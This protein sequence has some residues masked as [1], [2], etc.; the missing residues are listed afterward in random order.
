MMDSRAKNTLIG[1]SLLFG[2]ILFFFGG[3]EAILRLTGV[4]TVKPNPPRI[5]QRSAI[6]IISYELKP[7]I[8]LPAYRSTVTTNSLGF[9]SQELDPKK[10][11][12]AVL[13]DSITFGYGVEDAET[14]PARLQHLLPHYNILN[15]GVPGYNLLQ[16][17]TAYR[18]K[19]QKLHPAA[20][21]LIFH[22]NDVEETNMEIAELDPEGILRPQG[23]ESQAQTCTPIVT[24]LLGLLPGKCWLDTHSTFY[25]ALKKYLNARQ[26]QEDL[27][28]QEHTYRTDPFTENIREESLRRY[29]VELHELR[30][31]L[32]RNLPRLFIIWPERHLH[33]VARP[34]LKK[35]VQREGFQILDL[36]EVFGNRPQTLSWDNVHPSPATNAEAAQAITAAMKHYFV[37]SSLP[38]LTLP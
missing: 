26:A 13:G 5:Y 11:L 35:I 18:E 32:P 10:P 6:P 20:L 3:I 38:P 21:L 29:A 1:F 4:V 12:I 9:R 31:L 23:W 22:F 7:N 30:Q 25:V 8:S 36:Y 14:V 27:K 37:S 17:R 19:L 24:G 16:Q 28:E 34:Q 33:L 2:S 15:T